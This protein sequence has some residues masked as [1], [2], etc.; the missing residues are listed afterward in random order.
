MTSGCPSVLSNLAAYPEVAKGAAL[1]V[2]P[3]GPHRI[4]DALNKVMTDKKIR[5]QLIK[6][7]YN[8]AKFFDRIKIARRV[9]QIYKEVYDD[10]KI[11]YQP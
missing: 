9:L 11:N 5:E 3:Y 7:G 10:Y 4:A 2:Y 6:N 8:R 1:F